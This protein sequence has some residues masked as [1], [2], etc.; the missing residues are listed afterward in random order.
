MRHLLPFILL[1][2]L[3]AFG[4]A[5][6]LFPNPGFENY[7]QCPDYTSQI[8]RCTDWDSIN[9]TADFFHCGYYAN[10]TIG[11]YGIPH[12]GAGCVGVI[13]SPPSVWNPSGNWHGELFGANLL[14][15]LV[16]GATYRLNSWWVSPTTCMPVTP[17]PCFDIGFYFYKSL[18]LPVIL[19]S[20]CN[21][22]RPQVRIAPNLIQVSTYTSFST[23]FV[24]D[25]CYDRVMIGLFCNDSTFTPSCLQVGEIDYFD[26]DDIS[27]TKIADPAPT[28]TNFSQSLATICAGDTILFTN[29]GSS[30]RTS[31]KWTF[32]GG[33]PGSAGGPGPHVI[34]YPNSGSYAATLITTYECG[35]DTVVQPAAVQV[36]EQPELTITTDTSTLCTGT[37]R[38]L[39]AESNTAVS[40][41]TGETG[42]EITVKEPGIYLATAENICG[43]KTDS[44][45]APYNNCPCDLWIP[46][47]FTPNNDTK[48]EEFKVYTNCVI[49]AFNLR[50]YNR[51]GQMIYTSDD[52][53]EGW[54]GCF[55]DPAPVGIYVAVIQY[56]G[57]EYGKIKNH[58]RLQKITLIR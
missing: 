45:F 24:A 52:M 1:N 16:P 21:G 11:D 34:A 41:S 47:A 26:V 10:S 35:N 4:W 9:G 32:D 18:H 30:D 36:L 55:S 33:Q 20:G 6:N 54:D 48:N 49:E 44:V 3:S 23:D 28:Q 27:L 43:V 38:I 8:E 2:L 25:S 53:T 58:E 39:Y 42:Q 13:C 15:T 22:L 40:W 29:T 50:I 57:W 37:P 51:F 5:Q 12:T 19:L 14:Q 31:F 46:N 56:K 17:L 7:N